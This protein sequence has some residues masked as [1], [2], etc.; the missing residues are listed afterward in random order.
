MPKEEG[1]AHGRHYTEEERAEDDK[2]E[3]REFRNGE[4]DENVDAHNK[5]QDEGRMQGEAQSDGGHQGGRNK[6]NSR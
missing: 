4:D 5:P 3:Q 2:G 1:T 6:K